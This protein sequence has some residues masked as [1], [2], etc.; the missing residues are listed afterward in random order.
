MRRVVIFDSGI[1][2]FSILKELLSRSDDLEIHY[3]ADQQGFPYGNKSP[4]W[5]ITRLEQVADFTKSIKPDLFVMACNTA[6]VSGVKLL[7]NTLN[8]PIVAVE[9]V[10]KPLASSLRPLLLA[11]KVTLASQRTKDLINLAGVDVMCHTPKDL[12]TAIENMDIDQ[13]KK[14]LISVK[15]IVRRE[16]ID[17]IGLSCTHYPL[18]IEDFERMMIGKKIVDPSCAVVSR[19]LTELPDLDK[20][21][22]SQIVFYTTLDVL[23]LKRQIK[24]YLDIESNPRKIKL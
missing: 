13:V 18:V 2:G 14:I 20:S 10:V 24:Y 1:G 19:I 11:T 4:R 8:C 6:T 7:R 22:D 3:L 9:P 21:N 23:R 5:I 12:P 15:E 17:T 16:K